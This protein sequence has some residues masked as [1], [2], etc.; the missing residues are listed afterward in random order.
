[1]TCS[2]VGDFIKRS[3]DEQSHRSGRRERETG[4]GGVRQEGVCSQTPEN[5]CVSIK[6]TWRK[7][8]GEQ[9][10]VVCE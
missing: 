3:S 1:M 6:E 10:T 8:Q 4:R 2:F 9:I 5:M 7:K